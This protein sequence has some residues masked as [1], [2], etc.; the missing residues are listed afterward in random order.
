MVTQGRVAA[1]GRVLIL[2]ASGGVGTCCVFLGKMGGATVIACGSSEAKLERLTAFGADH[3]IDYSA[4]DFMAE[5]HRRFGR[6]HR[7]GF[8][9]GVDVVINFTGGDTWV[10]SLRCLRRGGRLLTCGAT[11][12]DDPATGLAFT[13]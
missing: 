10:P 11:P 5:V 12:G 3:V 4:G 8:E 1:G 9:G 6:P 7:R 2:G 13:R